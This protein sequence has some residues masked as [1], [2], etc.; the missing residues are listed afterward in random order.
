VQFS[1]LKSKIIISEVPTKLLSGIPKL[2]HEAEPCASKN[3]DKFTEQQI[4]LLPGGGGGGGVLLAKL[5]ITS[6]N[7]R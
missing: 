4:F 5:K 3:L 1:L 6:P 2:A 7:K